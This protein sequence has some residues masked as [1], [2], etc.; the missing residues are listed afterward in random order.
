MALLP[1]GYYLAK[2]EHPDLGE[3]SKS[4]TPAF[5][6]T[7][8]ILEKGEYN[9][10]RL[11]W[12]GWLTDSAGKRSIEQM[13]IAG[14]QFPIDEETGEPDLTNFVGVGDTE[15]MCGIEV[16]EY[17][18]EKTTENPNPRTSRRNRTTFLN[19]VGGQ[20]RLKAMDDDRKR[21]V[22]RQ[23]AATAML[24]KKEQDERANGRSSGGHGTDFDATGM[25]AAAAA[26][27]AAAAAKAAT[28]ASGGGAKPGAAKAGGAA[29]SAGKGY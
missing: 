6:L 12:E 19:R 22:A 9:G 24:L 11:S 1:E 2:A 21:M 15:F 25:E 18:P 23:F 27:R 8:H 7:I 28:G 4:G 10:A 29:K 26:E 20:S 14:A 3:S 13:Q 5:K 17:T 16:E